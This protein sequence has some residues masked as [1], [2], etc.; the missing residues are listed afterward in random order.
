MA[1]ADGGIIAKSSDGSSTATFDSNGSATGQLPSFPTFSWKAAYQDGDVQSV[2]VAPPTLAS[3]FAAVI[4]GNLSGD[5]TALVHHS[6]ALFWCGTGYLELGS[7]ASVGGDDVAFSYVADLTDSNINLVQTQNFAGTHPDWVA[8][9]ET[10]AQKAYQKAFA[11]YAIIVR[12]ASFHFDSPTHMVQEQ[13][14]TAYVV[15]TWPTPAAAFEFPG[16]S[17]GRIFYLEMMNG[18]QLA[19]GYDPTIQ[20]PDCGHSWCNFTPPYPPQA[21]DAL[22]LMKAI[23]KAIGNAAAHETGHYLETA[24]SFS[25]SVFPYMDCGLG[26]TRALHGA[27]ACEVDN[28]VYNFFSAS[29]FPQIPTI[30][31]ST[32]AQFFF[33]DIPGHPIQWGP[34][35]ICWLQNYASP[36]S[37]NKP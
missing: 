3:T 21:S 29:G 28:F 18:T 17:T 14:F 5:G 15:G 34:K 10:E 25:G 36:G 30:P 27:I 6:F 2:S 8:K 32:G 22:K 11:N 7:C 1:T 16:A 35:N 24:R 12:P 33:I 13:D 4:N 9:I 19:L 31:T 23:G 20:G 37:C 26:N